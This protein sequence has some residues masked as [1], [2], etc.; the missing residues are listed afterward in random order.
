MKWEDKSYTDIQGC[1]VSSSV[2]GRTKRTNLIGICILFGDTK[3]SIFPWWYCIFVSVRTRRTNLIWFCIWFESKIFVS[4]AT[5]PTSPNLQRHLLHVRLSADAGSPFDVPERWFY[6]GFLGRA[7]RMTNTWLAWLHE[8]GGKRDKIGR[9]RSQYP[10]HKSHPPQS[11]C[12]IIWHPNSR[13][14]SGH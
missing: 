1:D 10:A 6:G 7:G 8:D 14:I 4:V 12:D 11:C 13:E 2:S 5:L 3:F 9:K